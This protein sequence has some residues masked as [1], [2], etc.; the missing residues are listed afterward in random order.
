MEHFQGSYHSGQLGLNPTGTS[1]HLL[2]ETGMALF[3]QLPSATA[4]GCSLRGRIL[5]CFQPA[6]QEA[7]WA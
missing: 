3:H 5:L 7:K 4:V 1:G 2:A 6:A